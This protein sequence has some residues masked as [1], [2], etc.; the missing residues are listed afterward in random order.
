[1]SSLGSDARKAERGSVRAQS[2]QGAGSKA[3]C[4][5]G[6]TGC[7]R[8]VALPGARWRVGHKGGDLKYANS[9]GVVAFEAALAR[10]WTSPVPVIACGLC[11]GDEA[12]CDATA[13]RGARSKLRSRPTMLLWGFINGMCDDGLGT[14]Y[15]GVFGSNSCGRCCPE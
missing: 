13:L 14:L 15:S 3:S 5:S 8:F 9:F 12:M 7:L 6:T 10:N 2:I 4:P 1:V 11:L